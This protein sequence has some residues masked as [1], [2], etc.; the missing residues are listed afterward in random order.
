MPPI[1]KGRFTAK[2]DGDFVV[3][4]IGMRINYFLLPHKWM[5]VAAAMPRMLRELA[6]HPEMGL[7]DASAYLG[8]RTLMTIQYWRSFE[9]LHA[10]A[11]AKNLEH[12]PAWAAFNRRVGGN[13][14]VGIFHETY[15]VKNGAYECVY[16]NMPQFGLAK[17]GEMLPAIGRLQSAKSR[18]GEVDSVVSPQ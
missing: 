7:L 13:G 1:H 17:A 2:I 12:L 14:A 10:Y 18:L 3:F 9:Q 8:G 15:L 16:A 6:K 4:I 5:P 11:H